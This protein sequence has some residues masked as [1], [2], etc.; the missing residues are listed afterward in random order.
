MM[1][2]ACI[3]AITNVFVLVTVWANQT[4]DKTK[5]K[6]NQP[7]NVTLYYD[8]FKFSCLNYH[9]KVTTYVKKDTLFRYETAPSPSYNIYNVTSVE[10]LFEQEVEQKL[11]VSSP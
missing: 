4:D 6:S 7:E 10:T 8:F 3:Y 9:K 2:L 5:L 1:I 11:L